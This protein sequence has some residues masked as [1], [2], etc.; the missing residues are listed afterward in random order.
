[1]KSRSDSDMNR[2]YGKCNCPT[3]L[4]TRLHRTTSGEIPAEV[5]DWIWN[6]GSDTVKE[7]GDKS[8]LLSLVVRCYE[9]HVP[10]C[11]FDGVMLLDGLTPAQKCRSL[12]LI[13]R[14]VKRKQ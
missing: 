6:D 5:H 12:S 4:C 11:Q 3:I 1:M 13:L 7:L 8:K 14:S 2:R 9:D 10:K